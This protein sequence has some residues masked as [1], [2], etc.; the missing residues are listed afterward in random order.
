MKLINLR[1]K[2]F[3][4]VVDSGETRIE[5]LQSLVGEN[6]AGK[7]NLPYALQVFLTAGTGGV[8]ESDFFDQRTSMELTA[9]FG[10]LTTTERKKLRIYLLGDKLILQKQISL[11][12]DKKSGKLKL[13]PE[14]HGYIAKPKNW[15]LSAD[16]VIEHEGPRPKW[17]QVAIQNGILDYVKDDSGKVTKASY[18]AGIKING[19]AS[20]AVNINEPQL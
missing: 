15:W 16:G 5:P 6:N 17:E 12:V 20:G 8:G 9:T 19:N 18:E 10:G 3:R 1:V 13:V 2:N 14:Y 4:S 11:Q 7:S